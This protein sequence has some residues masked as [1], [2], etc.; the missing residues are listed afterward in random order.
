MKHKIII[1]AFLLFAVQTANAESKTSDKKG[2]ETTQTSDKQLIDSLKAELAKLQE[3][4]AVLESRL[5]QPQ[6]STPID[7]KEISAKIEKLNNDNEAITQLAREL[8]I[9]TT[10]N[11]VKEILGEPDYKA[12]MTFTEEN[13]MFGPR[14]KYGNLWLC[15]NG[16]LLEYAVSLEDFKMNARIREYKERKVTNLLNAKQ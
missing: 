14:L 1:A 4:I 11:K 2:I 6:P 7:A 16:D 8:P 9:G 10:I 3:R 13:G 5:E 12:P 15:F